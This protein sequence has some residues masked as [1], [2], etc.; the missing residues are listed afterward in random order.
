ML[1]HMHS[2]R[3]PPPSKFVSQFFCILIFLQKNV[4]YVN[5]KKNTEE[6]SLIVMVKTVFKQIKQTRNRL[7][8]PFYSFY[9]R[10]CEIF[11][12][13]SIFTLGCSIC[14]PNFRLVILNSEYLMKVLKVEKMKFCD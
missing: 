6:I 8:A 11:Q 5:K 2:H 9:I 12:K 4:N 3:P 7:P 14:I 10:K 13:R 1:Q